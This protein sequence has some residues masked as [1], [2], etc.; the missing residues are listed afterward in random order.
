MVGEFWGGGLSQV[1]Q[2]VYTCSCACAEMNQ[3]STPNYVFT[4]ARD[5][6]VIGLQL[7]C[8]ECKCVYLTYRDAVLVCQAWVNYMPGKGV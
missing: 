4:V 6:S 5:R 1:I 2:Y 7:F 8:T 3:P